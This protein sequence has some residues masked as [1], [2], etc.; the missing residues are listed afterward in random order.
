MAANIS[1]TST[2]LKVLPSNETVAR[3]RD[4]MKYEYQFYEYIRARLFKQK[5]MLGL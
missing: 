2:N 5:E 3:L 4:S 1:R